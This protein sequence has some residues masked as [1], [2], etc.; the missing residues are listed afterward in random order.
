MRSAA[1]ATMAQPAD[2]AAVFGLR[3][4]KNCAPRT[5][6][7]VP[8]LPAPNH[9][10]PAGPQRATSST[11]GWQNAGSGHPPEFRVWP[12]AINPV[13][14]YTE[15]GMHTPRSERCHGS[16]I[17]SSAAFAAL[18]HSLFTANALGA[19]PANYGFDFKTIGSP[20]NTPA[21]VAEYPGLR[22]HG[23]AGQVNYQFRMSKTEVTLSQWFDFV[24]AYAPFK[25]GDI[26]DTDFVGGLAVFSTDPA[27]PEYGFDPAFGDHSTRVGWQYAARYCNWLQNGKTKSAAAFESGVYDTAS[28][29]RHSDGTVTGNFERSSNAQYWLPTLDEWTKGMH[30]DP[31]K[32]GQG[33]G[34][35]WLYPISQDTPPIGGWPTTPGTQ[36]PAGE[37]PG[38]PLGG[39]DL[40]VGSYPNAKSPWGLLDGSGGQREWL[41]AKN[42]EEGSAIVRGSSSNSLF[43]DA[44][45]RLDYIST[46]G[47]FDIGAFGFRVASAV[48]EPS[49]TLGLFFTSRCI[50]LRRRRP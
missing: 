48:P 27:H 35:Y 38:R 26:A 9:Q 10:S 22:D 28:W 30:F 43:P 37:W 8:R 11:P 2:G 21:S 18:I 36:T 31:N 16:S 12:P 39:V 49:C 29:M 47:Y 3:C 17:L 20:G 41:E 7:H 34:G 46:G 4:A 50:L 24:T 6:V 25:S 45:D 1:A 42:G 33:L 23:P 5:R 19:P 14:P 40:P 44:D 13:C 15:G 32:N